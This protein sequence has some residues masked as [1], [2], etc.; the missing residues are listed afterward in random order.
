MGTTKLQET[1]SPTSKLPLSRARN[2]SLFNEPQIRR[3]DKYEYPNGKIRTSL[4][5]N[6]GSFPKT[7]QALPE[8]PS[9]PSPPP[10]LREICSLRLQDPQDPPPA[11]SR[12]T[13]SFNPC[14]PSSR[15]LKL[16]PAS[17]ATGSGPQ[18]PQPP[19]PHCHR[20]RRGRR[21]RRAQVLCRLP[22]RG[23]S[24]RAPRVP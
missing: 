11:L 4:H 23:N 15:P 10:L 18:E 21:N 12:Q 22:P 6:M 7:P 19:Q 1:G 3:F 8:A 20:L 9:L 16:T 24:E 13:S 17:P 14:S 2:R 5:R